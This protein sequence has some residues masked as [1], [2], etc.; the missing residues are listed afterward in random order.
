M[1][2]K[3]LL[4][5]FV[6]GVIWRIMVERQNHDNYYEHLDNTM[7]KDVNTEST[8]EMAPI[9]LPVSHTGE[10]CSEC[11]GNC[12]LRIWAGVYKTKLGES[13]KNHCIIKCKDICVEFD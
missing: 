4:G 8:N 6:V 12:H 10:L 1:L 7:P 13:E 9:N 11:I 5:L 3:I 2:I